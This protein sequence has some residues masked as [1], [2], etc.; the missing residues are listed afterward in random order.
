MGDQGL[1]RAVHRLAHR[2]E[3][4]TASSQQELALEGSSAQCTGASRS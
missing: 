4:D 2:Q 1:E 3:A